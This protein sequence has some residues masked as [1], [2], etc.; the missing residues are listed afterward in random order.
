MC[1]MDRML[2]PISLG[3][4]VCNDYLERCFLGIIMT[5]VLQEKYENNL[6]LYETNCREER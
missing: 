6:R 1:E 4:L 2:R 5:I 3:A